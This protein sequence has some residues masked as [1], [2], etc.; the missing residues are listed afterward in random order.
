MKRIARRA[1]LL[2]PA[3]AI[4]TAFLFNRLLARRAESTAPKAPARLDDLLES[5]RPGD[6][7]IIAGGPRVGKTDLGLSIAHRSALGRGV[8]VLLFSA[9]ISKATVVERMLAAETR[10]DPVRT[11]RGLID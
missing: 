6:L 3:G 4:G 9:Q 7:T 5:L 8:P 2:V 11:K 10:V 1:F